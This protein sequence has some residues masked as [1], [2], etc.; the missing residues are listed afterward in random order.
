MIISELIKKNNIS[1]VCNT[2][3]EIEV[4]TL[5][6]AGS[7]LDCNYCTFL[8]NEKYLDDLS[9]KAKVILT[10]AELSTKIKDLN[11]IPCIVDNPRLAFFKLHN[12]LS[13]DC[14][15]ARNEY[16]TVIG[17]GCHIAKSAIIS[18]KNVNIGKNVIIE[19]L[20]VIKE[21]VIIGDN[22]IIRSGTIVGGEGFEHKRDGEKILSVKHLGGVVIKNNVEL[23]Q[24]NCV[25]KAIYPWDDTII[26]EGCKTDNFVH[27]AHADK[28]G[29]RV[30]IAA[31]TCLA[32]RITTGDDVWIGPG[33]TIINGIT[34]GS[35]A[36]ISIGSVVT[37][38]V[39][40]G[41]Q[42]TGNFAIEHS[43]FIEN[44][45]KSRM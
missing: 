27:I 1:N 41:Q 31:C 23:Q 45:K 25:D 12:A 35:K 10:T 26:E 18:E 11:K 2:E 29:K 13:S 16:E 20:V 7:N 38:S 8:D 44:L 15:Y 17:E 4:E 37:K 40:E 28:L 21:N 6:L 36:K 30:F 22:C 42:V 9:E 34:I 5:G 19:D 32:G 3:D 43:K 33:V 24:N 14:T 39:M